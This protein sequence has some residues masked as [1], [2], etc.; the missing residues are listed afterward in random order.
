[1]RFGG[2][3]LRTYT[4]AAFTLRDDAFALPSMRGPASDFWQFDPNRNDDQL[5]CIRLGHDVTT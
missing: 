5:Q 3:S 1:M 2:R 4:T